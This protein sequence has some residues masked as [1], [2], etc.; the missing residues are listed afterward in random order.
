MLFFSQ[1]PTKTISL[2]RMALWLSM[3][4]VLLLVGTTVTLTT[5]SLSVIQVA[6]SGGEESTP[7]LME[8]LRAVGNLE[9]L[10]AL[11]DQLDNESDA[12]KWRST[13]LTM[14]AMASQMSLVTT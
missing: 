9:R 10:I 11:G 7:R 5:V 6:K 14:Q 1:T 3:L 8:R 4:G 13:A 2:R 12:E